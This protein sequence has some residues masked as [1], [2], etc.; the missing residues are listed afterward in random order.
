MDVHIL[1]F[2]SYSTYIAQPLSPFYSILILIALLFIVRVLFQ[3]LSCT[4]IRVVVVIVAI[5]PVVCTTGNTLC[6]PAAHGRFGS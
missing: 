1:A 5:I 4:R 3:C 2:G 6:A